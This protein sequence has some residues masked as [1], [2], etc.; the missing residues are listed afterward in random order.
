M[1]KVLYATLLLAVTA[2]AQ[3]AT[4]APTVDQLLGTWKLV[5][6]EDT[7][8]DGKVQLSAQFGPHPQGFIMYEPDGHMC[9]TIVDGDR[10]VW[11]DPGK[12]TDAEKIKY[13]DT[14][15][16]YCGTFNLDSATSTVTHYPSVAWTPTYVGSTQPRP[17]RLDG[18]KLIITAVRGISD[19]AIAKR[20]L[21]WERAKN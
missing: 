18:N 15:I 20:T 21:V 16:A 5:S 12:P 9:A 10:P 6:I 2:L 14:L 19:P 3:T 13:Y 7:M 1:M 17:F 11:K 4:P 8:K